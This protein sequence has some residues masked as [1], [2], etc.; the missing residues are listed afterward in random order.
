GYGHVWK[1]TDGGATWTDVSGADTAAD[2]FPDVPA[3]QLRIAPDGTL[4]VATDLGVFTDNVAADGPGHG[5]QPAE[6]TGR[7]PVAEPGRYRALH[8]DPRPR[9]LADPDA[10]A[11]VSQRKRP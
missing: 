3:N 11:L 8:R 4:V 1:T 6:L 7:V 5:R 2:S 9:H 10:V